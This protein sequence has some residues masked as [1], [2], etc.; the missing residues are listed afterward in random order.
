MNDEM[1]NLDQ[2]DEYILNPT[3]REGGR[4]AGFECCASA[5]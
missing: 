2:A 5:G 4:P 3:V 1:T